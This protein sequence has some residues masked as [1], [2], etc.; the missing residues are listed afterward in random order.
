MTKRT[1][2]KAPR[3]TPID[4]V[5]E[6]STRPAPTRAD[7]AILDANGI[8][9]FGPLRARALEAMA[10]TG[11]VDDLTEPEIP[12]TDQAQNQGQATGLNNDASDDAST[13][14]EAANG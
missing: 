6:G 4:M 14:G 2:K 1:S 12:G 5:D 9:A 3:A 10:Q 11:A 8:P 13:K 7:G